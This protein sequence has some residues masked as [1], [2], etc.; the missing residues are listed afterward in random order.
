M[1]DQT[2]ITSPDLPK[3]AQANQAYLQ[4]AVVILLA[5]ICTALS[6]ADFRHG[7]DILKLDL[8][9]NDLNDNQELA[10]VSGALE[11]LLGAFQSGVGDTEIVYDDEFESNLNGVLFGSQ[12]FALIYPNDEDPTTCYK[13][14]DAEEAG[15]T[16][17]VTQR[18]L[19]YRTW[20]G[21]IGILSPVLGLLGVLCAMVEFLFCVFYPS[22]VAAG[23]LF[24]GAAIADGVML[25]MLML[26]GLD[27][28]RQKMMTLSIGFWVHCFVMGGYFF[29]SCLIL[30][31]LRTYPWCKRKNRDPR[32]CK[33]IEAEII[34]PETLLALSQAAKG[35]EEEEEEAPEYSRFVSIEAHQQLEEELADTKQKLSESMKALEKANGRPD[36][37]AAN[38]D[39]TKQKISQS[40]NELKETIARDNKTD[41]NTLVLANEVVDTVFEL[42]KQSS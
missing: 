20:A 6:A 3:V 17:N 16:I 18:G 39:E 13:Y 30:F 32:Y 11:E 23:I 24:A 21:S 41:T 31:G 4:R 34:D 8:T 5:I 12:A 29:C 35:N 40:L 42:L 15:V 27:W 19:S 36:I 33:T 9:G 14:A 37:G 7:C 28:W 25:L 22:V 26:E 10:E 1:G 38:V 2:F